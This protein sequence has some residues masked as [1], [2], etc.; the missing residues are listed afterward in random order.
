MI[1][2]GE[3]GQASAAAVD[4][5]IR[6]QPLLY[7]LRGRLKPNES[8]AR[9][10]LEAGCCFPQG[11]LK[12]QLENLTFC[13]QAQNPDGQHRHFAP[14]SVVRYPPGPEAYRPKIQV[15]VPKTVPLVHRRRT[16]YFVPTDR[17]ARPTYVDV[18]DADFGGAQ[19]QLLAFAEEDDNFSRKRLRRSLA[20]D[21][22]LLEKKRVKRNPQQGRE[23]RVEFR[24]QW[25][26]PY[27]EIG[28][29]LNLG[30]STVSVLAEKV[31]AA[32]KR[33]SEKYCGLFEEAGTMTV[34]QTET[35]EGQR[36][37]TR[38]RL[39]LTVPRD[40]VVG[41]EYGEFLDMLGFAGKYS[42]KRM[43]G[44]SD[45][46]FAVF[47]NDSYNEPL[48]IDSSLDFRASAKLPV[49]YA[50][51][52]TTTG[53]RASGLKA[54]LGSAD[55]INVSFK[56][57][58]EQVHYFF[59]HDAAEMARQFDVGIVDFEATATIFQSWL[60]YLGWVWGFKKN[61]LRVKPEM[62]PT[63]R[64]IASLLKPAAR[65]A[66]T[67][68]TKLILHTKFAQNLGIGQNLSPDTVMTWTL[69]LGPDPARSFALTIHS[70]PPP[71]DE[72]SLAF[73][74]F[75]ELRNNAAD[76]ATSARRDVGSRHPKILGSFMVESMRK[77]SLSTFE[78]LVAKVRKETAETEEE[79]KKK[80]AAKKKAEEEQREREEA[81]A[82][83][84]A[85]AQKSQEE[86]ERKEA[87]RQQQQQQQQRKR[88]R[89]S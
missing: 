34:V 57:G 56:P 36:P 45:R 28:E 81:A 64:I 10:E 19:Q 16:I 26:E 75:S 78:E 83:A 48:V 44:H 73:Q 29:P 39:R 14:R 60:N 2:Y 86:R 32:L 1:V 40:S 49:I 82:A 24:S 59:N 42:I 17:L 12:I 13:N 43:A 47:E 66:L 89:R 4:K 23:Y 33:A 31:T 88:R 41:F 8:F 53:K 51:Y 6:G 79:K 27:V 71:E 70:T 63:T 61:W 69:R 55:R 9:F 20:D 54:H 37:V 77:L 72:E 3:V 7:C 67:L 84:A 38:E 62:Q 18:D 46:V 30:S 80:E 58:T 74:A 22:S 87:R 25:S 85:A 52:L 11:V 76:Y 21:D 15:Q 65:E 35:P 5:K 50:D 68:E